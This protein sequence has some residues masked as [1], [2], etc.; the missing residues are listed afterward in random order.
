MIIRASSSLLYCCNYVR[1]T[2]IVTG[3]VQQQDITEMFDYFVIKQL[4]NI[5]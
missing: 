2:F 5:K 1:K 3:N 4:L